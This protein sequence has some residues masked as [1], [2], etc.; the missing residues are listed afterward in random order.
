MTVRATVLARARP[1]ARSGRTRG[2]APR[3]SCPGPRR[4]PAAPPSRRARAAAT[5]TALPSG[6]TSSALL[7]RLSTTCSSRP[8]VARADGRARRRRRAMCTCFSAANASHAS[9]RPSITVVDRDRRRRRRRLLGARE[10]EQ[11][12]D[13]A[14]EPRHL[15][16]RALEVL[17]GGAVHVGLEVLEPQPHRR[18]RRAQLVRRVG[19]ERRAARR[20]AARG[21]PR[22]R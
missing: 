10:H 1:T 19:D 3:R 12:V 20:R 18:E 16:E 2:H 14:R 15:G 6:A 5:R 22:W 21:A 8:G 13:Q 17:G 9:Q 11:A 4:S 7:S